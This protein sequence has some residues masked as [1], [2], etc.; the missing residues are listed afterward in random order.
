[1]R[2]TVETPQ[3]VVWVNTLRYPMK[4]V[5]QLSGMTRQAIWKR[6]K[7]AGQFIPRAQHGGAPGV[8][9]SFSC[10]FC[11]E[12][13]R[14]HRRWLLKLTSL[15]SFC[16]A[17]CYHAALA[18]SGDNPWRQGCHIARAIVAQ[19]FALDRDHI[20]HH[21]DGDNCN[22]D[23]ANLAVYASDSDHMAHHRGRHV[24]PI[25]DG[26]TDARPSRSTGIVSV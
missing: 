12:P 8:F 14:R 7:A 17:A 10:A 20:V 9:V 19:R 3:L 24:P 21:K 26:A 22:N 23:L 25:W 18:M 1:M 4:H 2:N 5:E 11:R 13:V 15:R 6:L 16:N